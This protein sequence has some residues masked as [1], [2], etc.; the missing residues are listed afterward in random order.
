M[1]TIKK[2][3]SAFLDSNVR[4]LSADYLF[5][6]YRAENNIHQNIVEVMIHDFSLNEEQEHAF[7]IITNHTSSLAPKQLKMYLGRM[8]GTGKS[9]VIKAVINLFKKWKEL[10]KFIILA[11]T[12]TATALLNRLTYHH[13]FRIISQSE[14]G[15][16]YSRNEG[17]VA[18]VR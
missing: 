17:Q 3:I 13:A 5:K 16:I 2:N 11:L 4:I 10:Q 15:I 6:T 8:G 7:H 9:Q 18:Q 14:E 12:G 1:K